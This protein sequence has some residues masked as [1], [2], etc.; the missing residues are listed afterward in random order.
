MVFWDYALLGICLFSNERLRNGKEL[1]T[2]THRGFLTTE[3]EGVLI[4]ERS[5]GME[6]G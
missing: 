3:D 2:N 6:E 5:L 4:E 1:T